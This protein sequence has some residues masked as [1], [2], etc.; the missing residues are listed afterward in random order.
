MDKNSNAFVNKIVQIDEAQIQN[1]LDQAAWGTVEETINGLLDAEAE[2]LCNAGR[3]ERSGERRDYRVGHYTRK[4][5]TKAGE[6]DV[7]VPG[8]QKLLPWLAEAGIR[9][10]VLLLGQRN[11]ISSV[12]N[13]LDIHVLSSSGEAFPNVLAEAM[14]CETP[15]VTT[16][17]GDAAEIVGD[18]GWVV[19]PRDPGRLAQAIEDALA[20][21]GD[22]ARWEAR[23]TSSRARI[24]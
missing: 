20:E 2:Q 15:C 14:A 1:H 8:N 16:D 19:L 18:T 4:L 9:D 6:V 17:V 23:C 22:P 12:M 13:A 21:R 5:R 11:D 3:Y 10:R 24:V 7:K